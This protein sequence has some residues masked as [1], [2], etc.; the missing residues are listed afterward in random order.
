MVKSIDKYCKSHGRD[1][2]IA[3]SAEKKMAELRIANAEGT[4]VLL[5]LGPDWGVASIDPRCLAALT[6]AKMTANPV[7]FR[8]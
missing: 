1:R 5:G 2:L 8:E 6:Y 7:T 4:A 3:S